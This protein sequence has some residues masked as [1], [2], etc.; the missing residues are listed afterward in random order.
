LATPS[1]ARFHRTLLTAPGGRGAATSKNIAIDTVDFLI[2]NPRPS[3]KY[4][5]FADEA[6]KEATLDLLARENATG[7][8]ANLTV[9][10]ADEL[11]NV[12]RIPAKIP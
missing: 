12:K 8:T 6:L 7:C 2:F 1:L 11:T 3:W 9:A 5:H 4:H 10:S